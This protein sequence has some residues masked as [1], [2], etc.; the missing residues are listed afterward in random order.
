MAAQQRPRREGQR[1]RPGLRLGAT[2]QAW[3]SWA[4]WHGG[5]HPPAQRYVYG[6][7]PLPTRATQTPST[8]HR[9]ADAVGHPAPTSL[10]PVHPPPPARAL[11]GRPPADPARSAPPAAAGT[12]RAAARLRPA[13]T[14]ASALGTRRPC[15]PPAAAAG[16]CRPPCPRPP[17][18]SRA[19]MVAAGL[20]AA[21]KLL[22]AKGPP[23]RPSVVVFR[24]E[25]L[26][27][28]LLSIHH[29][30]PK[31]QPA[32]HHPQQPELASRLSSYLPRGFPPCARLQLA[33]P[34]PPPF[35]PASLLAAGRPA[36]SLLASSV[37]IPSQ[38]FCCYSLINHHWLAR[39]AIR[40]PPSSRYRPRS[41]LCRV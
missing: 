12:C 8:Q 37:I 10:S 40:P 14:T 9:A 36:A 6:L 24:K 4:A 11:G 19:R 2:G 29:C 21:T 28:S 15:R 13:P 18:W 22:S 39:P 41:R 35:N 30:R 27:L 38:L 16:A 23:V 32:I 1:R 5:L 7:L 26:A 31:R 33:A 17:Y 34:P 25:G 20:V 3:A